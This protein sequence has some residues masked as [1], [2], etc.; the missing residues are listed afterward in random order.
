MTQPAGAQAPVASHGRPRGVASID[1]LGAFDEII[2][3]RSPAEFAED[4][5]PGSLNCPVLD[6]EERREIGTLYKQVSPFAAR[7]RG[8][9]LVARNIATH[10]LAH[11]QERGRDW[12]PLVLCWRGGQRSGAMTTIL[13]SVGWDAC[14]LQGGY[15]AFRRHVVAQLA[16]LPAALRFRVIE[17]ATGSG[18]TRI[19]QAIAQQGGC[20]L[21]LEGLAS[22][23]GSVLGA[24]PA[25]PQPGQKW[26]ET[27]LWQALSAMPPGALVFVEGESRKIGR[28][29]LPEPLFAAMRAAERIEVRAGIPARV[30]F[31]LDDYAHFVGDAHLL[32]ARLDTLRP[33]LGHERILA[34]QALVDAGNFAGLTEAL[35]HEH[36]DP[37]YARSRKRNASLPPAWTVDVDALD[38]A[39]VA[40]AA[41]EIL[42]R[43]GG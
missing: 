9:A 42:R 33:L 43:A 38:G 3:V 25:Q 24:L 1:E 6:D 41:A 30:A 5:I 36:Y 23:R 37:L 16:T 29:H 40:R 32:K 12:R 34:W 28:L 7:R 18:K 26:F 19:L 17:G 2:D 39:G 14:Q 15:R 4:R 27:Q 10:L 20:V 21:D 11:F 22:H 13:R 8:A 35:L 31:L